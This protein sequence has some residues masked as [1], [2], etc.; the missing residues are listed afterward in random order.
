MWALWDKTLQSSGV[1]LDPHKPLAQ[2]QA[3]E[4]ARRHG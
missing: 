3:G 2:Q 4:T 1:R